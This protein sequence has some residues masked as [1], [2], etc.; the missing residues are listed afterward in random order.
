MCLECIY[1]ELEWNNERENR[2]ARKADK[3]SA[4]ASTKKLNGI[5]VR[6]KDV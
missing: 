6:T 2:Q 3:M 1:R 4:D 5:S